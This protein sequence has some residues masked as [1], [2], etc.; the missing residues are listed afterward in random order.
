M[1]EDELA[2]EEISNNHRR[3]RQSSCNQDNL[4]NHFQNYLDANPSNFGNDEMAKEMF[5]DEKGYSRKN[6]ILGKDYFSMNPN[7][8]RVVRSLEQDFLLFN[9]TVEGDFMQIIFFV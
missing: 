2:E 3:I 9:S 7:L 8:V 5:E 6:L 1:G 4:M